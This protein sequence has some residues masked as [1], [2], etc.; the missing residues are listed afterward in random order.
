MSGA[1][2]LVRQSFG[3]LPDGRAVEIVSL[4]APGIEAR[5]ITYGATLQAL[6]VPDRDGRVD[7]VVL[8][9]DDL[10]GYLDERNFYGATIG[11][12]ANRIAGGTFAI[13]G[14]RFTVPANDGPNALHGGAEGFD[15]HLW[16][17]AEVGEGDEPFVRLSRVSPDGECGFPGR[18]DVSVT[19]ACARASWRSASR[20]ADRATVVN[21][22]NHA[23]FNLGGVTQLTDILG[24][25]LA[26][27]SD[28]FLP[29]GDGAI[30]TGELAAVEGTAFDFREP[31]AI[32]ARIRAPEAQIR[33]GR[34]Y[35]HNWCLRGASGGEPRLAATLRHPSNGRVMEL[36][37][38]QPGVQFYSGNF[39]N[40]TSV[41][42]GGLLHRMGDALCLEP[43][44][45][46]DT[47]N[48]PEFPS[49][50]LNQ[51]ETYRHRSV[52]RFPHA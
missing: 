13:D 19:Y 20:R 42:K 38:D 51:G 5:V 50:R 49:A 9:H 7:D 1:P 47:P 24:H 25:E 32:G 22:T 14:E 18:L 48:R 26:I 52:Y 16:T 40:G 35:D 36:L 3:T 4:R 15:R 45:Y 34:G 33:Q 28:R 31:I 37:T 41:G 39:L 6:L 10:Q 46:P 17:I 23:F 43:Q 30:P 11:R 8:G 27:E 29:V 12:Y 21:L 44:A 2:S